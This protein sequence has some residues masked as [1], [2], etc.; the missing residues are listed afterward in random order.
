MNKEYE[1]EDE[2][3]QQQQKKGGN[4]MSSKRGEI[5]GKFILIN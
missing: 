4:I 2:Q 3:Q 1:K 5:T